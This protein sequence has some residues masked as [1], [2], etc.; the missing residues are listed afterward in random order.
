MSTAEAEIELALVEVEKQMHFC[1]R[2]QNLYREQEATAYLLKG[3]IASARAEAA[4]NLSDRDRQNRIALNH[5][6][7]ALEIEPKNPEILEYIAHQH[8]AL[9]QLD[10]AR[11][12]YKE[13]AALTQD[14]P[15]LRQQHYRAWLCMGNVLERQY[16]S[17]DRRTATLM[18][19]RDCLQK[20]L[21]NLP[22]GARGQLDH[23]TIQE[24]LGRVLEKLNK[25]TLPAQHYGA[26]LSIYQEI[27]R[28][29]PENQ[30]AT[31]GLNRMCAA[32][33]A[34]HADDNPPDSPSPL[35]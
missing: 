8:Q 13:L 31:A 32:L 6:S 26:A 11:E 5:F 21:D 22:A 23:A 9:D 30:E 35:N 4:N 14:T 27:L 29:E 24:C 16:E 20:A 19:A 1:Q 15:A 17:N 2:S 34:F 33:A 7:R 28:R 10:L 3:A 25:L 12:A 18:S